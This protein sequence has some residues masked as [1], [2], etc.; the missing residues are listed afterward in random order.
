MSKKPSAEDI[1]LFRT[2]VGPLRRTDNNNTIEPQQKHLKPKPIAKF[3][4]TDE[5]VFEDLLS[6]YFIPHHEDV[7]MGDT[8]F[9]AKTLKKLRLGYYTTQAELDL[10]GLVVPEAR[11]ALV[12]FLNH[13]QKQRLRHVHIIHGKGNQSKSKMPILKTYVNT[14]LQQRHEV[15]AFCSAQPI[16]GGTG[17]VYVLLKQIKSNKY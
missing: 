5:S 4:Q 2:H 12:H 7:N 6:D 3:R 17:A 13:C 15:L 16:N 1:E 8:L 9:Y 14:W 11:Q 10:H